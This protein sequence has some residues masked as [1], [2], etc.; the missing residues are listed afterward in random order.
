MSARSLPGFGT[1]GRWHLRVGLRGQRRRICP[2]LWLWRLP[3]PHRPRFARSFC[4][5]VNFYFYSFQ[6]CGGILLLGICTRIFVFIKPPMTVRFPETTAGARERV[7]GLE[8]TRTAYL[9][10]KSPTESYLYYPSLFCPAHCLPFFFPSPPSS[11][12]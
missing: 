2:R 1:L 3:F 5:V 11:K 9:S 4:F 8:R 10:Q 12:R 6:A 7:G